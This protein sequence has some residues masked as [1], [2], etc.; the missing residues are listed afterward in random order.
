[1]FGRGVQLSFSVGKKT[2][3][4]NSKSFYHEEHEEH[5]GKDKKR[6]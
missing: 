3:R 1:M 5:E 2:R 4:E 6:L